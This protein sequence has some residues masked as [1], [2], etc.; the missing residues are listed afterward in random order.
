ML[1]IYGIKQ[2]KKYYNTKYTSY[3]RTKSR[4]RG[5]E[6]GNVSPLDG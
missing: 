4:D 3:T 5:Q 2:I 1:Y 6:A